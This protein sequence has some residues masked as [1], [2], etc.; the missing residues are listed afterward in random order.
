[1]QDAAGPMGK[2]GKAEPPAGSF[3]ASRA[4]FT[5]PSSP[6]SPFLQTSALSSQFLSLGPFVLSGLLGAS[7]LTY[8][9]GNFQVANPQD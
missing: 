1:M 7:V 6:T 2:I 4:A 5:G 3:S 8:G 9:A